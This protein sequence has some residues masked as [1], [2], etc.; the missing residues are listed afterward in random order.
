[1]LAAESNT[2]RV[3]PP[4]HHQPYGGRVP[5]TTAPCLAARSATVEVRCIARGPSLALTALEA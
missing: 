5:I 4:R 3:R 1:M 2:V